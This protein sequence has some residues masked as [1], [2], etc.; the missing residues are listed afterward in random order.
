MA[1]DG[2]E[3]VNLG[4]GV[5]I[6]IKDLATLIAE[7][8][9]FTGDIRWDRAKPNGQPRRRLSVER[10]AAKFGFRAT[11]EFREGLSRTIEWFRETQLVKSV[12]S[13][14]ARR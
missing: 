2:A 13:E 11:T 14:Q 8:M 1:Y 12:V 7:L 6:S 10:A 4:T 9:G 3:P 5:E